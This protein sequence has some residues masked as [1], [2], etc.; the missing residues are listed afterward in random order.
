VSREGDLD[1]VAMQAVGAKTGARIDPGPRI[2]VARVREA[3]EKLP[4]VAGIWQQLG[5]T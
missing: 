4:F 3:G 1:F 2:Y 5:R